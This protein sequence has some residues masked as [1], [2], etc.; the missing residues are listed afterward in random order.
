MS[1]LVSIIIPT[2]NREKYITEAIDSAL[3]QTYQNI[4][5]IVVDDGS[6]DKTQDIC[7]KYGSKIRYI[8]TRNGGIGSA[9]NIGILNMNGSWFK[10]LSSDDVLYSNAVEELMKAA[11]YSQKK[12]A[13][14]DYVR[15]NEEGAEID[16]HHEAQLGHDE[17]CATIWLAGHWFIG[18]GSS[19]LIH[20]SCFDRVGLFDEQL[21]FQ[22][23][24]DWWLRASIIHG[25]SFLLVPK[26]LL[27]YRIHRSQLTAE[28]S[29]DSMLNSE[30]IRQRI[31]KHML[32]SNPKRWQT[33]SRNLRYYN[34]Y[35]GATH[36][37]RMMMR[38][39]TMALPSEARRSI[40][41]WWIISKNL[42][43]H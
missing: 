4:E 19:I 23:D 2:Y 12:I 21:R 39:I 18:N 20:K 40:L 36:G 7:R 38:R 22:E 31:K 41:R 6:T 13:Y 3:G 25:Y 33:F 15:I 1:N 10:W 34:R 42:I 30:L 43:Q 9:L 8:H 32:L 11:D 28:V 37:I 16:I 35:R 24:F 29:H 17:F 26:V 14:S 5:I 27:K